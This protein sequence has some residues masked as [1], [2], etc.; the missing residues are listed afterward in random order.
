MKKGITVI[1]LILALTGCVKKQSLNV[2]LTGVVET[3][4]M[5][6]DGDTIKSKVYTL[7]NDYQ[8]IVF[9]RK[10][11]QGNELCFMLCGKNIDKIIYTDFIS[12][13][14]YTAYC[15]THFDF[16]NYVA[17]SKSGG[18]NNYFFLFDKRTG[19]ECLYGLDISSDLENE[20]II[21]AD[22]DNDYKK[23][24]YD[25]NSKAK[26]WINIDAIDNKDRCMEVNEVWKTLYIKRKTDKYYYI[27]VGLCDE[28][29]EYKI[30]ILD[31]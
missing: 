13:Y 5:Y 19:K 7:K 1:I 2:D 29:L 26:T 3:V 23:Y 15:N 31:Y 27:G 25:V 9:P 30:Q 6:D 8:L 10:G 12:S 4:F 11:K 22:E 18:S 28:S 17:I 20:L 14:K 21:Y 16:M 24:V